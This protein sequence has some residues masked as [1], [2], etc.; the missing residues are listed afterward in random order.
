MSKTVI[1]ITNLV[2]EYK[3]YSRKKDKLLEAMFPNIVK[4]RH[5]T[6][7]ATNNLDLEIKEGEVVG[8]EFNIDSLID[9]LKT[10]IHEK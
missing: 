5:G 8:A 7:R 9:M 10:I 1:K 4:G 3:M 6:F 2:K